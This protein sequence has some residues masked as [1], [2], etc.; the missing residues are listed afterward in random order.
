[1]ALVASGKSQ[2]AGVAVLASAA[3]A[4]AISRPLQ[5]VSDKMEAYVAEMVGAGDCTTIGGVRADQQLDEEDKALSRAAV[6]WIQRAKLHF[7]ELRD[8]AADR[9][10][11][12]RWLA[13]EMKKA[14]MRNKDACGLIPIVVEMLFV[15]TTDE[16]LAAKLRRSRVAGAMRLLAGTTKA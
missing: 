13:E 1:M 16:V 3:A 12:K 9:I 7:G 5:T 2:R 6:D 14:D 15:P 8:S 10:C 4:L 11:A